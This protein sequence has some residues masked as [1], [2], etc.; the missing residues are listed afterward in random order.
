MFFDIDLILIQQII[1][2]IRLA[3]HPDKHVAN[4]IPLR[5]VRSATTMQSYIEALKASDYYKAWV[6][7][8][9]PNTKSDG[10]HRVHQLTTEKLTKLL[11]QYNDKDLN[12]PILNLDQMADTDTHGPGCRYAQPQTFIGTET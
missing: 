1:N 3:L 4:H 6:T 12:V 5:L 9:I 11:S 2:K 10:A 8:Q 7:E